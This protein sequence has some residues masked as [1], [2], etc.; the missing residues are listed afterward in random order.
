MA[1]KNDVFMMVE[2]LPAVTEVGSFNPG[3]E[4]S[5][6]AA[7]AVVMDAD[8]GQV[9][10]AKNCHQPKPIASTTKIMTALVAIECASLKSIATISPHAAG[11]EGSSIYLKAGEKLVL[12]ELLFGALLHSGNDACVA[13]AEHVAG[14]EEVFVNFM[15]YK[16]YRLGAKNTHF[17]NTN[18]LPND[19]HFS[20]AFDL[21]L[22]TCNAL[23]NP[24]FNRMVATKTHS[25]TGP[26]GKRFLS[27]T[28]KMLWS[29]QG[30]N[31]VKTG[32]TDA[33]GKCLVSSATRDGRRLIAVVLHSEDRWGESI[34]LLNYGFERF[35]NRTVAVQGE[36]F[37]TI[38]IKEGEKRTVPV[39]VAQNIVVA[40]PVD[41]EEKV[42]RIIMMEPELR[43][44]VRPGQAV[45]KLQVLVEGEM[46]GQADLI[47][48]EGTPK[49]PA[50]QMMWHKI[51]NKI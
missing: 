41:K 38:G 34:R 21:A 42:E 2:E 30:A 14:R 50:Y 26:E 23:K 49:L 10:Y 44:P 22:I 27:N 33:A 15:N 6:S 12:E 43:A 47:T 19:Q 8:T 46:V 48:M 9:L 25:I 36:A 17:C 7:S 16:A 35:Q 24:V 32:T 31:G 1:V 5:L 51:W 28:N 18:G 11:T 39:S 40:L 13:I 37:S 29:Y 20:S 3:Q 4:L 45:G